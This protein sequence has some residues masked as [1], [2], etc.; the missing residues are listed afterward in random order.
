MKDAQKVARKQA[1]LDAIEKADLYASVLGIKD[2]ELKTFTEHQE[3]SRPRVAYSANNMAFDRAA[4]NV[5]GGEIA[6]R[7]Q[8]NITWNTK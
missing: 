4:T 5:E 6:V 1:T 3:Y 2:K 8:V 7:I